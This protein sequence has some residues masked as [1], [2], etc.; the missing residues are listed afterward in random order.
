[1]RRF[2]LNLIHLVFDYTTPEFIPKQ[3]ITHLVPITLN[4]TSYLIPISNNITSIVNVTTNDEEVPNSNNKTNSESNSSSVIDSNSNLTLTKSNG[5]LAEDISVRVPSGSGNNDPSSSN[6]SN[7]TTMTNKYI[8]PKAISNGPTLNL[9]PSDYVVF[10]AGDICGEKRFS[11]GC[12][13]TGE[14]ILSESSNNP[15]VLALG[16]LAYD[17]GTISEFQMGYHPHWGTFKDNTYPVLGNHE[18]SDDYRGYYEYFGNKGNRTY[19]PGFTNEGFYSFD[20][21]KYWHIV[22]LNTD[23]WKNEQERWLIDDLSNVARNKC[24][25][26]FGHN[27][28]YS[29]GKYGPSGIGVPSKMEDVFNILVNYNVDL[30][31]A[32][33]DHIYARYNKQD[34]SGNAYVNGT[35]HF[36]V[37][38][39]GINMQPIY[40]TNMVNLESYFTAADG[41]KSTN[42][43][44]FGILRLVLRKRGY[45]FSYIVT[46]GNFTDNGSAK[47]N[48]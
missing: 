16:D 42:I 47:C 28:R 21:G 32:G 27:P 41:M 39:G 45:D 24:V 22:A 2:L 13:E 38:T 25:L 34:G 3:N 36:L 48:R 18:R 15:L 40:D 17:S 7:S 9:K 19:P 30:Y 46:D 10:A 23:R 26:V 6:L 12:K 35:A 43:G 5:T 33:H 11:P 8:P 31:L 1:M 14:I 4:E 44:P 29:P 37:G 20:V